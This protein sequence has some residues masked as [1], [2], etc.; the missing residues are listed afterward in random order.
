M[1]C[2]TG[3]PW[4]RRLRSPT[5]SPP[6]A[7]WRC[8]RSWPRCERPRAW[9]RTT[10]SRSR[11]SSERRCSRATT[12]GRGRA[13]S[14]RSGGRS[15][16]TP[17]ARPAACGVPSDRRALAAG[18]RPL[19]FEMKILSLY[20][21]IARGPVRVPE[22]PFVELPVGVAR[23]LGDVVDGPRQLELCDPAVEEAEQLRG[24]L[25]ARGDPPR[26]LHHR[27][28]LLAPLLVGDAEDS[29]VVDRRVARQLR[30]D[31]G[32]VD[33]DPAR[34]DHVALAVAQVEVAVGVEVADVA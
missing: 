24:Q 34:D 23:E 33:V 32:R 26:R 21:L 8:A 25:G 9:P 13:R 3:R 16:G 17:D 18:S 7:R 5:R 29:D 10:R 19:P 31:L 27:L 4:P 30:L 2:R 12:R 14:R 20:R 6:T 11:P 28:D 15:S 1:S 22:P